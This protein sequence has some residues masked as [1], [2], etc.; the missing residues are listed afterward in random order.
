MPNYAILIGADG[1]ARLAPLYDLASALPYAATQARKLK[2]AM[3]I[4]GKY[5]LHEIGAHQW[6]K[7]AHELR[8]P[9]DVVR[10]SLARMTLSMA[11]HVSDV[12]NANDCV[13]YLTRL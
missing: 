5:R 2:L 1:E 6:H 9:F 7:L 8:F 11:D 3:K 13:G 12:L 10:A 4:G